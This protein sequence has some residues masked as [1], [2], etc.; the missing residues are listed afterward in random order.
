MTQ[1]GVDVSRAVNVPGLSA[2]GAAFVVA[3]AVRETGDV[4]PAF[5]A[6]CRATIAEGL[7]PGGYHWLLPAATRGLAAQAR[8]FYDAIAP[9]LGAPFLAQLDVERDAYHQPTFAD[10]EGF[11]GAWRA[12]TDHPLVPYGNRPDWTSAAFGLP[13][14][15][16]EVLGESR[17]WLAAY[18][19]RFPSAPNVRTNYPGDAAA[20]W[21]TTFGGFR[22]AL[23]QFAGT[24][25]VGG[26]SVDLDAFRGSLAALHELGGDMALYTKGGLATLTLPKGTP[27]AVSAGGPLTH[28]TGADGTYLITGYDSTGTWV[29]LDGG[30]A[31][32][33]GA[34]VECGWV[35]LTGHTPSALALRTQADV[36]AAFDAGL[37]AASTALAAVPRRAT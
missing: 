28:T 14:D 33:P 35:P 27:F 34:L 11:Y 7:V 18:P 30:Y 15:A 12:L 25:D 6:T 36:D 5:A 1:F 31:A 19:L 32:A 22:V 17:F 23:W 21:S 3:R 2:A 9:F 4:D 20:T 13:S 29:A 10:V 24:V 8:E 26:S 16:A 37:A